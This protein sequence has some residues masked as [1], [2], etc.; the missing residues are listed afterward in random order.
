MFL[1]Y[2]WHLTEVGHVTLTMSLSSAVFLKELCVPMDL[3][4]HN[5]DSNL[6]I[7]YSCGTSDAHC[8]SGCAGQCDKK[9]PF[10]CP[11]VV[12]GLPKSDSNLPLPGTNV[13]APPAGKTCYIDNQSMSCDISKGIVCANGSCCSQYG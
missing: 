12:S 3:V 8:G 5:M 2:P 11:S 1:V 6:Y 13:P 9:I 10:F 4:V 7:I